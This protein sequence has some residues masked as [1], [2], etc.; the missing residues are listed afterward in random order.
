MTD[1]T[2]TTSD[3]LMCK[4]M[5]ALKGPTGGPAPTIAGANV[6]EP[7]DWP[8][9]LGIMPILLVQSPREVKESLGRNGAPQFTVTTCVH[10]VGRVTAPATSGDAGAAAVLGVLGVFQRQIEVAV[11]NYTP[12]M[13]LLQQVA[14]VEVNKKVTS[15]A[16]QHVGE[17]TVDLYL[18]FYQGPEAF[19]PT[20]TNPLT[21][22]AIYS[23][24]VNVFDPSGTYANP[25]FPSSVESAPRTSGPDGR[26]EGGL[27]IE[28][29]QLLATESGAIFETETG[30]AIET[31]N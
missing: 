24:L 3:T 12:L 28:L 15:D 5:D 30:E 18:E 11:V 4:V 26:T 9:E 23:D 16:E 13:V 1:E 7:R 27:L 29:G 17:V 22:I 20:T 8:T 10:L 25:P 14:R 19:C 31:G 2:I 6:F 21:E